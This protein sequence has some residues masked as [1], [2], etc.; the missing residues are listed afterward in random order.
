M[1]TKED[2]EKILEKMN[3]N[4]SQQFLEFALRFNDANL[5]KEF[6]IYWKSKPAGG[7]DLSKYLTEHYN[8]RLG[9]SL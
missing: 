4:Y 5:L 2:A 7:G 9:E 6:C 3:V 8:K 1:L